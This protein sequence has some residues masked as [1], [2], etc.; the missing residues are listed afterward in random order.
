[1]PE[2]ELCRKS[3]EFLGNSMYTLD[4]RASQII[5]ADMIII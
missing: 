5:V 1:M 3:A 4:K 2:P